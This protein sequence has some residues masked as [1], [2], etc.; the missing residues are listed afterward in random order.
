LT[1][2]VKLD[3]SGG[4]KINKATVTISGTNGHTASGST[5]ANGEAVFT[6]LGPAK[7]TISASKARCTLKKSKTRKI[8]D[9]DGKTHY[10]KTIKMLQGCSCN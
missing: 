10:T 8:K 2:T 9:G 3:G 7:Y 5:N 4:C 1:V 6:N